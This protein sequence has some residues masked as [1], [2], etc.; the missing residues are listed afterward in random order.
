MRQISQ[1]L[2]VLLT[3]VLLIE[4]GLAQVV[5]ATPVRGETASRPHSTPFSVAWIAVD[6]RG[7]AVSMRLGRDRK[8][9]TAWGDGYDNFGLVHI[10]KGHVGV[11][12]DW[13]SDAAMASQVRR[14]IENPSGIFPHAY[15][16]SYTYYVRCDDVH[17]LG[18]HLPF[19]TIVVV[20][21]R[22]LSDHLMVGVKTAYMTFG[23]A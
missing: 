12:R 15:N 2:L 14:T 4:P 17:F 18:L 6:P 21:T 13:P 9:A 7:Q 22:V 16:Q 20:D 8:T 5:S 11:Q 3:V 19:T 23:Y 1:R 10:R